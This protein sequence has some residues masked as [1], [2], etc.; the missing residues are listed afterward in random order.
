MAA[1]GRFFDGLLRTSAKEEKIPEESGKIKKAG[2]QEGGDGIRETENGGAGGRMAG[3]VETMGKAVEL[4]DVEIALLRPYERN[5]KQH[6]KE[7]V[8]KIGRSIREMGFLSPCLI[9]QDLNVIAGHGRIMAAKEIGWES[10]PC[11]FIEGLTEEQRKAYILADN[12]LTELGEWDMDMVQEELAA[13]ADADFDISITGFDPDLRFDDSMAGITDDGWTET[14]SAQAE[15]PRSRIGDIYQLGNHRLMCG[16]STDTEMVAELMAGQKADLMVTDPPYNIGLGGDESG[17]AQSTD[18]MASRRKRQEDGAFLLNDNLGEKEFIEFLTKAM[19]NAKAALKDGGAFYVW[20]ATRTTEQFLEGMRRAGL[21][22]K[23]IL[24]WVKSHFTLGRQDYQWQHEPCLYGWKEGA[25]HY[26]LDSRK[27]S[28]VVE[29]LQPDLSHMKKA[30]MEQ[31]LREIYAEET[32]TDVIHEAKPNVSELH[33]TM[34]PL[35]LIAR[36]IRNSS[37]PGETVLDLFGGSG[38]TLIACEQMDRKCCMMEFDP[39]YADVIVDR[40]E[41]LTGLK[42]LKINSYTAGGGYLKTA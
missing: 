35:K 37:K 26:F 6:S 3:G 29:D 2:S 30:E 31:L 40:W 11:V 17:A 34:K 1:E 7:Q 16:D 4:R 13:L 19:S 10:V 5:A 39:H 18:E 38:T 41:N 14:D 12:R 32:A 22:V 8:E 9:D 27:Q 25:G 15:E 20:Y 21:D 23:Q 28:T 33:P 36:Q 24:I 42:A